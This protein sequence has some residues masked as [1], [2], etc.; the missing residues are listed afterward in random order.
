MKRRTL[1]VLSLVLITGLFGVLSQNLKLN[2]K[3][4]RSLIAYWDFNAPVEGGWKSW[5]SKDYFLSFGDEEV[6]QVMDND[7]NRKVAEFQERQWLTIPR[8]DLN[9]LNIYGEKA[10]LT[11]IA[12]VKKQSEKNWQAIAGVWDESRSKRQYFMFLNASSK[13]HQEDMKR[14]PSQGRL[15]G[16]ISALGGKSHGEVAWISYASSKDPVPSHIWVWIALTYNGEEIRVFVNGKLQKDPQ[17]NPF[18]YPDGVFNGGNDGADFTVGANSVANRM[19]NQFVGRMAFL[20]V[21]GEALTARDIQKF[22]D[23]FYIVNPKK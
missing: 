3:L 16:H 19:T 4:E 9:D 21:F 10:T 6:G 11:V 20:G 8:D 15:H 13:T 17:M 14:Y 23:K 1:I 18:D 22:Q 7:L 5:N 2:H 12:L